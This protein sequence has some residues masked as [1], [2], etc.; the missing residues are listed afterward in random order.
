MRRAA[1]ISAAVLA[2]VA[3]TAAVGSTPQPHLSTVTVKSGHLMLGFTAGDLT[4]AEVQVAS[5]AAKAPSGAFPTSHVKLQERMGVLTQAG[6]IKWRTHAA[7][8][9]GVYFVH[10]AAALAG[11]VTSCVHATNCVLRWSNIVKVDVP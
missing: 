4:P 10:V 8:P 9:T 11:G 6:V 7:L 1:N 5:S 3:T 2:L